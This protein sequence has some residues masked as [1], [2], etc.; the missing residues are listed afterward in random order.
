[1]LEIGSTYSAGSSTIFC[2]PQSRSIR[3]PAAHRT[4]CSVVAEAAFAN[5]F[6]EQREQ[7]DSRIGGGPGEGLRSTRVAKAVTT[8]TSR[9]AQL[10]EL[11]IR[12]IQDVVSEDQATL[13]TVFLFDVFHRFCGRFDALIQDQI[14]AGET[15]CRVP[16]AQE[17][18][19]SLVSRGFAE[20]L[21]VR[22]FAILYQLR[23]AYF[24]IANDLTGTSRSMTE[25]RKHL[26][27]NV[28]T[29][30]IR[31]YDRFLWNRMEDF[32][33]LLLGET[34]TGKGTAAAAIGR[35]GFIPFDARRGAFAESFMRSFLSLNLSQFPEALVESELFGHRKGAFTGAIDNHAGAFSRC[36]A[37]GAIF[38][39]EIGEV[40]ETVQIK[41]LQ[42]LQERVFAPVGSHQKERFRG[43]VIAATNRPIDRLRED[44]VFR[45]DFFYRLCSDVIVVPALRQRIAEDPRELRLLTER[46]VLR[47]TG[48]PAAE[49]VDF[50]WEVLQ[51]LVDREYPWPGNVRELE[52]AVRRILITRRYEGVSTSAPTDDWEEQI[53]A[54]T[55]T[56]DELLTRYCQ[57]VFRK[58]GV[59]EEV[60]RR[61]G[62]DPRT[63]KRYV[64]GAQP[65]S[66][67]QGND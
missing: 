62:L 63:V 3:L 59:Y 52:Q 55:L 61:I 20:E 34:G 37:H 35:S 50:L 66:K 65:T 26:W 39:D 31:W 57:Q 45:E 21:A 54:G 40:R 33:T 51:E 6:G 16:F 25:L 30:D 42:V 48:E 12:R 38:L 17:A 13:Q 15:S 67:S 56:A 1:M 2:M 8:V 29:H 7:L 10:E 64:L 53:Q 9:L 44:G 41:L 46:L 28:F 5:P 24:F 36:S 22:M 60:A 23:R 27:N 58:C 18:I 43:R 32:S 49:M 47:M 4:F 19:Q 14:H 11:G